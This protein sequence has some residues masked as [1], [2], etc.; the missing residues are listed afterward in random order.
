MTCGR[1]KVRKALEGTTHRGIPPNA[2]WAHSATH[3]K[4]PEGESLHRKNPQAHP[5]QLPLNVGHPNYP[6]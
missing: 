5:F 1:I 6:S 3:F 4:K 2:P